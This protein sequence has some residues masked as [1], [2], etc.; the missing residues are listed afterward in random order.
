M[1]TTIRQPLV[2]TGQA[3]SP[4]STETPATRPVIGWAVA[5]AASLAIFALLLVLWLASGQATPT[6][7]G[8]DAI[9]TFMTV[10][11]RIHEVGF[12]VLLVW[13]GYRWVVK[14][15]RRDGRVSLDGMMFLALLTIYWQDP[16]QAWIKPAFIFNTGMLQFG[17][18]SPFVGVTMPNSHLYSEPFLFE[19]VGWAVAVLPFMMCAN[20][21]MRKAKARWPGLRPVHLVLICFAVL[22]GFDLA[23]EP[24]WLMMGICTYPSAI[25]WLSLFPGHYYQ[26]PLYETFFWGC[27]WTAMACV[28]Y[29]RDDRGETIAERGLDRV[30]AGPRQK[31]W[32]RF[33]AIAGL[34]NAL[35]LFM[36][37]IPLGLVTGIWGDSW[38]EDI[39]NRS[40]FTNQLCGPGTEYACPSLLD[41][42]PRSGSGHVAPDGRY[43]PAER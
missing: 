42:V 27:C 5:G 17:S 28:R 33:L 40:Y 12:V 7:N 1:A 23:I 43:V 3:A 25:R 13:L 20:W 2:P 32:L 38:P 39:V 24:V 6:P 34:F 22:A 11:I 21:V 29:F 16:I 36:Y 35:A 31:G 9:P 19:G 30:Q 4:P 18:W 8:A 14:P 10:F 37:Y 41:P 15:L 26:F